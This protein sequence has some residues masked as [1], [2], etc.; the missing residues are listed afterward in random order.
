MVTSLVVSPWTA[1]P[2]ATDAQDEDTRLFLRVARGDETAYRRLVDRHAGV[3][4][5]YASR[6][7]GSREDGE[8]V[9]Q[10]V[11]LRVWRDAPRWT[12]GRARFT[13]WLYRVT[14]NLCI[15]R[16]RQRRPQLLDTLPDRA[17]DAPPADHLI[18]ARQRASEVLACLN[19]LAPR[20]RSAIL[21]TYFEGLS[22][23][24]AADVLEVG[25]KALESLLTR[26]RAALRAE[27]EKIG[28]TAMEWTDETPASLDARR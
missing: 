7:L 15:D 19:R 13:T 5:R 17:D 14:T 21:L 11:F 6:F 23:R 3:V 27:F 8:E 16:K 4:L 1:A 22:N 2:T 25:V 12:P 28:W 24:E 26:G 9:V 18:V 10:E 20:Q